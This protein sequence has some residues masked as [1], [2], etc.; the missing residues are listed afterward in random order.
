MLFARVGLYGS[1]HVRPGF[2]RTIA[3]LFQAT[4]ICLIFALVSGSEFNSYWIFFGSLIFATVYVG[5]LRYAFNVASGRVLDRVG[6]RRRAVLVGTADRIHHVAATLRESPVA[7]YEAVGFFALDESRDNGLRD[8]GDIADL[9]LR[10][11]ELPIEEVIITDSD[12][13]QE[14]AV[15]VI[16][17]CHLRGVRVRVDSFDDR[18]PH[19]AVG[20]CPRRGRAAARGQAPRV[21]GH[22]LRRSSAASTSSAPSSC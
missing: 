9:P 12:F 18:G 4:V 19:P 11:Q 17:D 15:E 3:A 8:L 5:G 2:A 13:P 16:S 14:K 1:R 21:R 7:R 6:Y 20:A 10:L 22:R